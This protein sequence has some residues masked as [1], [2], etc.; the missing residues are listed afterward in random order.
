MPPEAMQ[1]IQ[2]QVEWLTPSTMATKVRSAYPSLTTAQIYK[3]WHALSQIFWRRA[4]AQLESAKALLTEYND[5][6]D[7][8]EPSNIPDGVEILA[9]GMKR[10]AG[11]LRGK[12]IEIGMDATC[13]SVSVS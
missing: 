2:E 13:K 6:V 1:M 7:I 8:F 4:E 5:E 3:A 12:V 11:P 9:W 10:I